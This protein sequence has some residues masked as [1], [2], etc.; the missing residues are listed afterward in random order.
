MCAGMSAACSNSTML[1]LWRAISVLNGPTQLLEARL[2]RDAKHHQ[3]SRKLKLL[4]Y[5]NEV[6]AR[7][8]FKMSKATHSSLVS[9]WSAQETC[10]DLIFR[11]TKFSRNL[12]ILLVTVPLYFFK[13]FS[14]WLSLL[15]FTFITENTFKLFRTLAAWPWVSEI[16]HG[17]QGFCCG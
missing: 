5:M 11:Q 9:F 2:T 6:R 15:T 14:S 4:S 12:V 8:T 7:T 17:C 13:I 16:C 3:L 1:R 10:L